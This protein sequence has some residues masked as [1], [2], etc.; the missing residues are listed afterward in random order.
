MTLGLFIGR[1]NPPHN[2][3]INT[4]EKAI[5]ENEK[6]LILLWSSIVK[7]KDK[8]PLTFL[9]RKSL[10]EKYLK[11]DEKVKILELPDEK[12]DLIWTLHVYKRICDNFP[13]ISKVNFYFWDKENDSAYR[14]VKEYLEYF[15]NLKINFVE[16]SR[17]KSFVGSL[18]LSWTNFRKLLI[19]KKFDLAKKFTK[20]EI[21]DEIKTH[22]KSLFF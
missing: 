10:L 2:W 6:V 5:L 8:N 16:I 17:K 4:I 22:F 15:F 18:E 7:D 3:H 9:E 14:C 12:S 21:F 20:K 13:N 1:M 19:E 11:N